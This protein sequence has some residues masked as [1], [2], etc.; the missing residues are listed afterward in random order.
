MTKRLWLL[1]FLGASC[2]LLWANLILAEN[3]RTG[4]R[5]VINRTLPP[6][7]L[8]VATELAQYLRKIT[9]AEFPVAEADAPF[10]QTTSTSGAIYIDWPAP[11]DN[12][13]L[14]PFE[15]RVKSVEKDLYLYGDGRLGNAFAAYDFLEQFLDCRF[16]TLRGV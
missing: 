7:E 8:A 13:P 9:G 16:Y 14:S 1:L 12:T 10:A 2:A 15:R 3:G 5:I 6:D 4:Y 11:G